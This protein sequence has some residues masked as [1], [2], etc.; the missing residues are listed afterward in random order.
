[1]SAD[2]KRREAIFENIQEIAFPLIN[3]IVLY[4]VPE[5]RELDAHRAAQARGRVS[6]FRDYRLRVAGVIRDY[7][8]SDRAQA[9][10]D[11]RRFHDDREVSG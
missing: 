6:V 8:K 11:S 3:G 7:G 5:I 10:R 9:P 4:T 2:T 1:M